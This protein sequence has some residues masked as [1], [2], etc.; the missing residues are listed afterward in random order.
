MWASVVV[1][2]ESCCDKGAEWGDWRIAAWTISSANLSQGTLTTKSLVF[3]IQFPFLRFLVW[4]VHYDGS[5]WRFCR[6]TQTVMFFESVSSSLIVTSRL[7]H[8]LLF[9]LVCTSTASPLPPPQQPPRP[10]LQ[11]PL[12]NWPHIYFLPMCSVYYKSN[13]IGGHS[14]VSNSPRND[15]HCNP[16]CHSWGRCYGVCTTYCATSSAIT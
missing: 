5:P 1:I 13:S 12:T 15:R 7:S 11:Q 4:K 9:E 2:V 3:H 6:V 14:M 16:L 10:S 8:S